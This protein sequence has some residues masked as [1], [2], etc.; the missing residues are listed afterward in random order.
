MA[1]MLSAVRSILT[2]PVLLGS[3]LLFLGGSAGSALAIDPFFPTFGNAGIDVVHY[4]IDLD[5]DPV[6]GQVNG[7]A[8]VVLRAERQLPSFNLD[9][10]ALT[11]SK[12]TVNGRTAGFA[13]ANDKLTITPSRAI[14]KGSYVWVSVT[15]AGVP[16]PLPDPT[17]PGSDLFLGWFKHQQSTYVVSE[18]V[19][20]S[21]FFPANDEPTDKAT[22][23]FGVTVPEGYTGVA[24]GAFV[25]SVPLGTKRRFNW[26]ML[27]PMTSWLATVHV[28]AFSLDLSNATDGTPIRVYTPE[29]TPETH[30][31]GYAKAGEMIPYLESKIGNYPFA[32][33]GSVVVKDKA[34]Y[35]A[36]ETQA[37]STFP[38]G[39]NPPGEDFIAHELTHQWFG[40]SVAVAKWEDLWIAE[41]T[42][43]Y[44]EV[45]WTHRDDPAAFDA[46]ML[47]IYDYV[48]DQQIGPAV[49]ESA[50]ELFTDR[51]YYRGASALYALRQ[52]VGDRVFF[53]ILRHFA[54]DNRGGN[55]TSEDFIRTAVR[56]SGD[57]SVRPLLEAWLYEAAVPALPGLAERAVRKGAPRPDH[58]GSRCG[59]GSHR[60]APANC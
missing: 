11:V 8:A 14:P 55:V 34:L 51:T 32:S 27:Q 13:Q 24:N 12:V 48:A 59:R 41:G 20:A 15:Y 47:D 2:R 56:Y 23:S 18:P 50:E 5:V 9:L 44:F 53:G 25:G 40:N 30:V 49:V 39:R 42:A 16:D 46:A 17:A 10:H 21:T 35:Y 6:S 19:G 38:A 54:Q 31:E 7:R 57:G 1:S 60:G 43:T 58:V 4:G 36:L 3:S 52:K 45:L 37:M 33:Y 22:Y 29:G 26:V 28:N